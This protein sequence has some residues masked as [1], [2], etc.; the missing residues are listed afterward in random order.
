MKYSLRSTTLT[1]TLDGFANDGASGESDNLGTDVEQVDGGKA[2]DRMTASTYGTVFYGLGGSD[3]LIGLEGKDKLYGGGGNDALDGGPN[4]DYVNGGSGTDTCAL[5]AG[6]D[7]RVS[8]ELTGSPPPTTTV[9]G[10]P[11]IGNA[12]GG[13]SADTVV[14]ATANWTAPSSD[15]GSAITGYQVTAIRS[16]GTRTT[17][18]VGASARTLKFTGLVSGG[19]YRFEVKAVNAVGTSPASAQSNQVTAR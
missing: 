12:S 15:G 11:V 10:A 1:V 17:K 3:T 14:S 5:S 9:P 19:L 8:C 7:T 2:A 18:A 16:T 4:N 13:G 6:V